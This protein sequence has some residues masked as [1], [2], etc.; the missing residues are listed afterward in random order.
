MGSLRGRGRGEFGE[1]GEL[2]GGFGEGK[3]VGIVADFLYLALFS[4]LSF[5]LQLYFLNDFFAMDS[6]LIIFRTTFCYG[7]Q[8]MSL[9]CCYFY[10]EQL[11][12][13]DSKTCHFSVVTSI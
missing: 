5:P 2:R 3:G 11:F 9:F 12:A 8:N 4:F 6:N 7:F 1:L 10:L 13:M